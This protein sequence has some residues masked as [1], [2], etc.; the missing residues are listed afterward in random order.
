[1]T[2][3]KETRAAPF[4]IAQIILEDVQFRHSDSAYLAKDVK[5]EHPQVS[6]NISV[7]FLRVKEQGKAVV[8][9]RVVCDSTEGPYSYAASYVALLTG[10]ESILATDDGERMLVLGTSNMLM[11]F[12]REVIANLSSRG[13]FGTTW[14]SPIDFAK[15]LNKNTEVP[16]EE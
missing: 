2:E 10:V 1:M 8:R 11:P 6:A 7:D 4:N 5:T 15:E 9:L 3:S 14:I 12:V 13:R 16:A